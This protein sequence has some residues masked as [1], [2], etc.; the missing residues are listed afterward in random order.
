MERKIVQFG[1]LYINQRPMWKLGEIWLDCRRHEVSFKRNVLSEL[2]IFQN[3]S[4]VFWFFKFFSSVILGVRVFFHK[5]VLIW[6]LL[7][8]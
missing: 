4:C 5:S 8:L 7:P 6:I 2:V 1:H 3:S